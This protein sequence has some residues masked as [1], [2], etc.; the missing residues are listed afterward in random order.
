MQY[1]NAYTFFAAA[2]FFGPSWLLRAGVLLCLA[3]VLVCSAPGMAATVGQQEKALPLLGFHKVRPG[4]ELAF[5]ELPESREKG[6]GALFV[7]LR[8]EPKLHEFSLS[9]ASESGASR[10]L[11]GWSV[12]DNLRA[13]INASMY[14]PDKS[15]ST[16]FMRKG[17]RLNNSNLGG[18]LG[19]FFV[20]GPRNKRLP[21]AAVLDKER[22][23]WRELLEQYDIVVQNYRFM[24]SAG[25][26]LWKPGGPSHSIAV[27]GED[28]KGR[29]LFVLS[30]EPLPAERFAWYAASFPLDIKTV[31]YVEGGA[32]AGLFLR[33]EPGDVVDADEPAASLPGAVA[34]P[35]NGGMVHV[36]KGWHSLLNTRGNTQAPLPNII[37]IK[38][39]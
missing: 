25:A 22:P 34:V 21:K 8:I 31:M 17:E 11:A 39:K 37:G 23:G 29:I 14:L 9:M 28:K 16:G 26:S 2:R 19:A 1:Q 3:L 20:A 35:L 33:L 36:W 12:V 32:Q 30:Q 18:R 15:T 7:A 13:G 4:L 5:V 6:S 24:D 27:V 10:S 38:R